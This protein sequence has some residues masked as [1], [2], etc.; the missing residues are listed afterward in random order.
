M[1]G[2]QNM[3]QVAGGNVTVQITGITARGPPLSQPSTTT[4]VVPSS[5]SATE[6]SSH[7][8]NAAI[9]SRRRLN[10]LLANE[11]QQGLYQPLVSFSTGRKPDLSCSD[12]IIRYVN[13]RSWPALM[14]YS[15]QTRLEMVCYLCKAGLNSRVIQLDSKGGGSAIKDS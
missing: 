5:A 12:A 13:V 3:L 9:N 11:D 15:I 2:D 10:N 14:I 8:E 6:P 4:S 1:P 7:V